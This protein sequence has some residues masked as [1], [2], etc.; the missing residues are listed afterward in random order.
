MN[1]KKIL[2]FTT[3]IALTC[4]LTACETPSP[5]AGSDRQKTDIAD[6]AKPPAETPA[7]PSS[8]EAVPPET[9]AP[10]T[11]PETG[12][13]SYA[14]LKTVSFSFLSGAGAW[15]TNM[16]INADGTFSGLYSDADMGDTG[17]GYPNGVLYW[18]AFSGSL[19]TPEKVNE[20][21]WQTRIRE[22]HFENEPGT[23]EI[24]D[25]TLYRYSEAYGLENA[26]NLL[27]YLPGA[28]TKELPEEYLSWV[29][30]SLE[31]G[32]EELSFVG[33]Y[34]EAMGEG[35][36]SYD[37][38]AN[39]QSDLARTQ[40]ESETWKAA[41]S[42]SALSDAEHLEAARNLYQIWD[43]NLNQLWDILKQILTEEEMTQ[44][45]AEQRSWI[46][47][48]E[49][50]MSAATAESVE[51]VESFRIGA[52]LTEERVYALTKYLP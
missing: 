18:C 47:E 10:Q 11:E 45:L 6:T 16:R 33:L 22:I 25:G 36:S 34:N 5:S 30:F 44:L 2:C 46:A 15:S 26:E 4:S 17:D 42:D 14:Q 29:F 49:E 19:D 39:Y 32:A 21:T 41:L 27:F 7:A 24:L 28:P 52:E 37:F 43:D 31:D 40:E 50:Q 12:E 51:S 1:I 3:A 48:K 13:F 20:Y 23:E 8:E 35:F 9:E 38:A